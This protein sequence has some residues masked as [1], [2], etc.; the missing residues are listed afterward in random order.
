[1]KSLATLIKLQKTYVD[2]QRQQLAKLQER[3]EQIEMQIAQLEVEKAREQIAA[4]QNPEA[5]ATYGAFVKAAVAKG[6]ELDKERQIAIAA[7]EA[8]RDK[9]TELF[10]E[11]KRYETAEEAR[12]AAEEKEERRRETIELDEIGGITHERNKG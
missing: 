7:V 1:M 4:E 12:I 5:R 3:L 8:A 2:E 6:R 11:Q 9:L 10:E